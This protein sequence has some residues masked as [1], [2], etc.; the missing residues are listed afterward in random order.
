MFLNT[1]Q[2]SFSHVLYISL[3]NF[4]IVLMLSEH[5]R[6]R[7]NRSRVFWYHIVCIVETLT[8]S[9]SKMFCFHV[10]CI[11][12]AIKTKP[13]HW[14][15]CFPECQ[16]LLFSYPPACLPSFPPSFLPPSLPPF[17]CSLHYSFCFPTLHT[18]K[19]LCVSH[20]YCSLVGYWNVILSRGYS[21]SNKIF[22]LPLLR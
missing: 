15:T 9:R 10:V 16:F 12:D 2:L 11:V 17:L 22:Y 7:A 3:Q 19:N 4:L 1:C 18:K 6:L 8:S 20:Q 5:S 13:S 14:M 21:L